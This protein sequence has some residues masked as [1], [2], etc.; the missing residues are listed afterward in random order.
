VITYNVITAYGNHV[1]W[2]AQSA[3]R[4][5]VDLVAGHIV[6]VQHVYFL[7]LDDLA[8][9]PYCWQKEKQEDHSPSELRKATWRLAQLNAILGK[10][11]V[12]AFFK[13]TF[14]YIRGDDGNAPS[15]CQRLGDKL[16]LTCN[17]TALLL[18]P[19]PWRRDKN[20]HVLSKA[21]ASSTHERDRIATAVL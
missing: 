18:R 2:P 17:A 4:S 20:I 19:I 13:P 7:S 1:R 10:P 21:I 15:F 8:Q 6:Q 16:H 9:P 3:E 12:F 14:A 11:V 5:E